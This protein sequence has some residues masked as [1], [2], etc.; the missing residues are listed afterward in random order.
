MSAKPTVIV[1]VIGPPFVGVIQQTGL[2]PDPSVLL[3]VSSDSSITFYSGKVEYGQGIRNGFARMIAS[4]FDVS[5]ENVNIVLADTARVP[6]DRGTT[7]SASTRTV[8][9]QLLRAAEAAKTELKTR[10]T[11]GSDS[12]V[13]GL[14]LWLKYREPMT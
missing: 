6:F 7:G 1:R 3:E 12:A 9:V 4:T 5:V 13:L 2:A 14:L 11:K 8:G 10:A